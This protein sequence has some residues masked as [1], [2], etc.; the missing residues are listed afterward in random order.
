[1]LD[2][3]VYRKKMKMRKLIY[4]L[5]F[6]I[7]CLPSI[8][9]QNHFIYIQAEPNLPFYVKLN[10]QFFIATPSGYVI[11]PKLHNGVYKVKVGFPAGDGI[12][13]SFDC[14]ID[15][16]DQG[17]LLKNLQK[18][19]A[20]FNLQTLGVTMAGAH[21]P[22]VA[23]PATNT[24]N[25]S[26]MLSTAL[27]SPVVQLPPPKSTPQNK[28]SPTYNSN[29]KAEAST[30]DFLALRKKMADSQQDQ[31]MIS[32]AKKEFKRKCF[33]TE[34]IKNLS[35]LFLTDEGKYN[36]FEAAYPYV[37]DGNFNSL[38]DQLT[39]N[40]YISRFRILVKH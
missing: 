15:N 27:N 1:M 23:A 3:Y 18:G 6:I 17:Y 11:L 28:L 22:N 36:F 2:K 24:D 40:Y 25:F 21:D 38:Q 7:C 30:D 12:L 9:Q 8:A 32:E 13:Q 14:T 37:S 19:W 34:E 10:D 31:E 35:V 26:A 39:D 5:L 4:S 29:C 16:K 20:L 33:T